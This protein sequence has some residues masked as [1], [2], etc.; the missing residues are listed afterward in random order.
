MKK[1]QLVRKGEVKLDDLIMKVRGSQGIEECGAIVVFM[2]IARGIGHDGS[3]LKRLHYEADK[4]IALKSLERIRRE[5]LGEN[6]DVKE[7]YITHVVDDLSPGEDILY[8]VSAAKHRNYA[9]KAARE[10]LERIKKETPI[11]KKEVT[12]KGEHWVSEKNGRV[13]LV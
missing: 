13:K 12:L 2:G 7:I 8:I 6:E 1:V 9:F 11:W 4:E 3:K 10:V 5:V